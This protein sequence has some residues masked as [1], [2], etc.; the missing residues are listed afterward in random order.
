MTL[1]DANVI[2]DVIT[3]DR[4]WFDWSSGELAHARTSGRVMVNEVAYAEIAVGI[5]TQVVLDTVL[6]ELGIDFERTPT[7]ALFLAAKAFRRYRDAGG[8]RL[9][10]LPDFFIGAHAQ[11]SGQALLTRDP[12]RF[13]THFPAVRLITP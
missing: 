1:V 9:T 8:P 4:T 2:L 13:R 3:A 7:D 10:I 12:R 11:I 6:K 5:E